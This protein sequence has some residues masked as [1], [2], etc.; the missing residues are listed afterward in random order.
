[1][2]LHL[3]AG[4]D[5]KAEVWVGKIGGLPI[6]AAVLDMLRAAT[7]D[8]LLATAWLMIGDLT[9]EHVE[10]FRLV[11]DQKLEAGHLETMHLMRSPANAERLKN[12]LAD[13]AAGRGI[14]RDL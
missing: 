14:K 4:Y 7:L 8:D 3:Y 13:I 11:V 12:A 1:M 9:E 5:P 2:M 6:Q 10:G